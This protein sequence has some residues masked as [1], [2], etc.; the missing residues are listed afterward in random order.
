MAAAPCPPRHTSE[1][2]SDRRKNA[3]LTPRAAPRLA[4]LAG[5]G[6]VGIKHRH[7]LIGPSRGCK[8]AGFRVFTFDQPSSEAA[9]NYATALVTRIKVPPDQPVDD[10]LVVALARIAGPRN[11]G[12][13]RLFQRICREL[14][15]GRGRFRREEIA[16]LSNADQALVY[17]LALARLEGR[18]PQDQWER[19]R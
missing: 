10:P 5:S 1:D 4:P 9:M 17:A 7:G 12:E 2:S 18:Y 13:L 6:Q 3:P 15:T 8:P 19:L 14:F 16:C 11:D